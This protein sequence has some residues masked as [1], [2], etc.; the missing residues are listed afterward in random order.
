MPLYKLKCESCGKVENYF[1]GK[2]LVSGELEQKECRKCGKKMLIKIPQPIN[3]ANFTNNSSR[4]SLKT[5]TGVGEI[6][7][8]PGA[9]KIIDDANKG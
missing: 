5:R 6:Q 2:V 9:K 1:V 8:A 4:R 3:S 7:F